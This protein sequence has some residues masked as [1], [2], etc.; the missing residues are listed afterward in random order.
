MDLAGAAPMTLLSRINFEY[1]LFI[2][3]VAHWWTGDS[4]RTAVLKAE[5]DLA[6]SMRKRSRPR[7]Q[8]AARRGWQTRRAG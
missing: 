5:I 8:E 4:D 6:L 1:S 2:R 3:R 7:R